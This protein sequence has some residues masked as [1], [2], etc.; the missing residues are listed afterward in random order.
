MSAKIFRITIE[1]DDLEGAAAF[2]AKL[3][4]T[5]GKRHPGARHYFDCGGVILAVLDP[6]QGGMKPTPLPKSLY[7]AVDDVEK[8][9]HARAKSLNALT[10]ALRRSRSAGRRRDHPPLGREVVLRHRPLGQR[11]PASSRRARSTLE[12]PTCPQNSMPNA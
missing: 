7:F 10:R 4:D 9:Q 8:A 5:P 2:Y 11:A 12:E 6:S 3:L 1:V